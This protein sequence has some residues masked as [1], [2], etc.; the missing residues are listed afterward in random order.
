MATLWL[1]ACLSTQCIDRVERIVERKRSDGVRER[2]RERKREG[3]PGWRRR[4]C[5]AG[6]GAGAIRASVREVG[7]KKGDRAMLG[8]GRSGRARAI[9][10]PFTFNEHARSLA[11]LLACLFVRRFM[12]DRRTLRVRK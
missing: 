7:G 11:R 2:E 4:Q 1:R 5:G 3:Y 8:A 12:R 10:P 9:Q 6:R